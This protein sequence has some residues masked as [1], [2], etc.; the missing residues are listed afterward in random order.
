[1]TDI[2]ILYIPCKTSSEARAIGTALVTEKLA[3]CVNV[4]KNVDSI[5]K[6]EGKVEESNEAVLIAKTKSDLVEKLT[7]RVKE[8][9]GY[10]CPCIISFP[11]DSVNQ[12][13][14][15]WLLQSLQ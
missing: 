4:I 11:V 9:H 14:S 7:E 2:R 15:E 6:W 5:Y 1:M 8:L 3:A 12:K 10:D 13:Y